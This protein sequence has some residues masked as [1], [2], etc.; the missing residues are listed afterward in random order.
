MWAKVAEELAVPWRAAEAMHWQLGE[1]DM[2]RRAGVVPFSLAAVN[3][4]ANAAGRRNSPSRSHLSAQSQL[5][6]QRH[7]SVPRDIGAPP[8]RTLY[9]RSP[10]QGPA[11][12]GPQSIAS[13]REAAQTPARSAVPEQREIGYAT[14]PTLA[15]IQAQGRNPDPG[16]LPG[17]AEMAAGV[18]PYGAQVGTSPNV[19]AANPSGS[20]HG[21]YMQQAPMVYQSPEYSRMKRPA[22]PEDIHPEGSYRRRMA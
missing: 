11:R 9:G 12:P 14:V 16:Y 8:P 21:G 17:I 20:Y 5:Q 2:A 1:Q 7:G 15:P 19:G 6:S 18:A 3:A 10:Q 13:R 4:E 22:S